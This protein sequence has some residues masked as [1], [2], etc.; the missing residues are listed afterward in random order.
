MTASLKL[1][2]MSRRVGGKYILSKHT[3]DFNYKI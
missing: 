1:K 2:Y 3:S